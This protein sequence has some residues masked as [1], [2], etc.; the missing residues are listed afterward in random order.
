MLVI[1]A[2]RKLWSCQTQVKR[3]ILKPVSTPENAGKLG[4]EGP[5]YARLLAMMDD[6]LGPSLMHIKYVSYVYD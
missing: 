1:S 5:L 6:M 2:S 4:Y 3:M